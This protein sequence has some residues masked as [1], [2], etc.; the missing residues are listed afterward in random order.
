[1]RDG[2]MVLRGIVNY[3]QKNDTALYLTGG[4][5]TKGKSFLP[6]EG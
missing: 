1:M 5:Y 3:T 2:N 4:I 6:V